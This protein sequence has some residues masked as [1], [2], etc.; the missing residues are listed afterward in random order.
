VTQEERDLIVKWIFD[1]HE[2]HTDV[3]PNANTPDISYPVCNDGDYPYVNSLA[4]EA[5]IKGLPVR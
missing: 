1:N 5:F 4:L 3:A 2:H